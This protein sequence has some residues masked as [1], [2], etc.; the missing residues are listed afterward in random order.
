MIDRDR[1]TKL[2][3]MLGS[4]HDGEIVNAVRFI[5]R[6]AD[7][8]KLTVTELLKQGL[9]APTSSRSSAFKP[10]HEWHDPF[11]EQYKQQQEWAR[12]AAQ[13]AED[14]TRRQAEERANRPPTGVSQWLR[15]IWQ[16]KQSDPFFFNEFEREFILNV[17]SLRDWDLTE[18]QAKTAA[19]IIKKYRREYAEP[20]I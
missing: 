16:E 9:G 4:D 1:L 2:V 13:Q 19:R 17:L 10:R 3:G 7:A 18:K 14:R 5:R 11:A 6:M 8:E 15:K 20:L 12:R